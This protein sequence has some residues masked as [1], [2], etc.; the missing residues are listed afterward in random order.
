MATVS[1]ARG[2]NC[3]Y[4]AN[5][6]GIASRLVSAGNVRAAC[7]DLAHIN[8]VCSDI[9]VTPTARRLLPLLSSDGSE[10]KEYKHYRYSHCHHRFGR[11]FHCVYAFWIDALKRNSFHPPPEL[12]EVML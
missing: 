3:L 10:A 5:F 8:V 11:E 6:A 9:R 12:N 2:L 1:A 4:S 7:S